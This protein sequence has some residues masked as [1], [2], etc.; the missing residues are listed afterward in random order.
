MKTIKGPIE[1]GQEPEVLYAL[2]CQ[3]IKCRA[4]L[5]VSNLE[6]KEAIDDHGSFFYWFTCPHCKQ[7]NYYDGMLLST[8]R[9]EG[10]T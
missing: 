5:E 2:P 10:K 6:L 9:I 1:K 8:Y 7:V 4:V 3:N